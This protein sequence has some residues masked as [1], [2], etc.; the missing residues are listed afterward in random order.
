MPPPPDSPR[1][2]A[3]TAVDSRA[4]EGRGVESRA[5]DREVTAEFLK[6]IGFDPAAPKKSD[7]LPTLTF[8]DAAKV[9]IAKK[10]GP[11]AR[12]A[13]PTPVTKE[14]RDLAEYG[15]SFRTDRPPRTT[16]ERIERAATEQGVP[17]SVFQR[18]LT[19]F[20]VRLRTD[21]HVQVVQPTTGVIA[22]KPLSTDFTPLADPDT[23]TIIG[24]AKSG[25]DSLIVDLDGNI[26]H[27]ADTPA[28]PSA[29]QPD[30]LLLV[31]GTVGKAGAKLVGAAARLAGSV[32]RRVPQRVLRQLRGAASA[33]MIGTSKAAPPVGGEL[34]ARAAITAERRAAAEI[35][36]RVSSAARAPAARLGPIAGAEEVRLTQ[37]QY[38]TALSHVFPA[39][40]VDN[41][42]S[43]V[44]NLGRRAA[45]RAMANP[46][47][48]QAIQQ[49]NLTL[50]GTFFHTA[51]KEEARRLPRASLPSGWTLEAERTIQSGLGGG[52]SDV[53]LRGPAGEIVEFDWK[54][55]GKSALSLGSRRE[56]TRHAGQI[57]ANVG[58]TL[59][60]QESRS[61]MDFVRPLLRE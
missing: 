60:V 33:V 30:D 35:G 47:F 57:R 42:A 17:R 6:Q 40:H 10:P 21:K 23:G 5:S 1:A 20:E 7:A 43:L 53:L 19:D 28:T 22:A 11:P 2:T 27:W 51:A 59:V 9:G 13:A 38:E 32:G 49:R 61:W 8:E 41:V 25:S 45:E 44:D 24:Y 18:P 15:R 16:T 58:G 52:R 54:T 14:Q 34:G 12:K 36:E 3:S 4:N 31:G 46:R 55:T 37:A 39:H 56:M 48:V 50:A 26:V 29:I